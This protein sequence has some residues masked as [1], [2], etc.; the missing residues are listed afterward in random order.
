LQDVTAS[1][2]PVRLL[3]A[4]AGAF[5]REHLGRLVGR[6]DVR[7]V[8]VADTHPDA[9][10]AAR[11][12]FGVLPCHADP[13]RMI[14]EAEADAIVIATPAASHV[15]ICM[16]A[17]GRGLCVLL[18]KPVATSAEAASVLLGS[19]KIS[20]G[21]VLPGHVLRFSKDHQRLVE[22]VGSGLIGEVIYVNSRRYRDDSHAIRYADADPVLT[23]LIHDVD[24]AQWVTRSDFRSVLAHRSVGSGYRSLTTACATTATGV[25]CHLRTAWTFTDGDLPPDRWEVVGN[26]GSVELVVGEGLQVYCEGRRINFPLIETDDP[27]RNEQNHFLACV[28]DRSRERALDLPEAIAGLKLADAVKE[29]LRAGREVILSR[30]M[31]PGSIVSVTE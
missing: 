27:L 21:F 30:A 7:L 9:L 15:E 12:L 29:S 24:L 13:L 1:S 5:G 16:R 19:V 4:G 2:D 28:R 26:R 25:V 31:R 22:I 6:A 11:S 23:T 17:L 3:L 14:D 8:G 20:S 18:E 10:K